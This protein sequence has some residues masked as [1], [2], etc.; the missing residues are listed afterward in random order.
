MGSDRGFENPLIPLIS[1]LAARQGLS[2]FAVGGAVRDRILNRGPFSDI[3]FVYEGGDFDPVAE[4]LRR[5][6]RFKAIPF[7]NKGFSTLRL[8]FKSLILDFQ[9][10]SGSTLA[11]D[12]AHRDFTANALYMSLDKGEW[13]LHDPLD[14]LTHIKAKVLKEAAPDAFS[15]DP[16]RV[17]RLF[18]FSSSLG[19]GYSRE[20]RD[21]AGESVPAITAVSSERTKDE[22]IKIFQR[23]FPSL[24]HDMADIGIFDALGGF[25]PEEFPP[26]GSDDYLLNLFLFFQI[27]GEESRLPGFLRRFRFSRKDQEHV[28]ALL[29]FAGLSPEEVVPLFH[30]SPSPLLELLSGYCELTGE[31]EKGRLLEDIRRFGK[32]LVDGREAADRFGLSGAALGRC[33]DALHI[34]QI[35]RKVCEKEALLTLFSEE[36][37]EY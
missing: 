29:T 35:E 27:N 17:L 36:R 12:A 34:L 31:R 30:K 23:L 10:L 22:L 8:C 26:C 15:R 32:P 11:E 33:L 9:P 16:L 3:D 25:R 20:T 2:L 13:I 4:A 28:R 1:S 24:L 14:G 19:F 21:L 6:V 18:R 7:R 37:K 5:H